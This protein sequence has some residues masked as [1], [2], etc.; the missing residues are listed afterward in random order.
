[1]PKLIFLNQPISTI[2]WLNHVKAD[3]MLIKPSF[4]PMKFQ[5]HGFSWQ[6]PT[7]FTGVGP[8]AVLN[9]EPPHAQARHA[10]G[11]GEA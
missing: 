2:H 1:M 3:F 9:D 7:S 10:P 4:W 5:F 8:V 11:L 6:L